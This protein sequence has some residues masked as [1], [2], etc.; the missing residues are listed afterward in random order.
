MD[1]MPAVPGKWS[2]F[3]LLQW[4]VNFSQQFQSE[5]DAVFITWAPLNLLGF[6][7]EEQI[8]RYHNLTENW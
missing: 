5:I 3:R 8:D 7:W 1:Y 6:V 4:K 2:G